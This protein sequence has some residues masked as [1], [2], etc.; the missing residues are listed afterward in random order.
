MRDTNKQRQVLLICNDVVGERMAGPGIR[1]WEFARVLSNSFAVTLTV[2]PFVKMKAFPGQPDFAAELV[3]CRSEAELRALTAKADVIVTLGIVPL[4]YPFLA[5]TDKPLVSDV[6]DPF[7]LSGL[8]QYADRPW[9]ERIA[10]HEGYR[11]AL[12]LQIEAADFFIC[13]S[14]KQRDYWLGMLSALGRINPYTHDDDHTL[15]RL[16]DVVP[17]G[18]PVEPPKHTT[19]VLK[20]VYKT[21]AADDKVILWGGGI[22]NWFDAPTLIRALASIARQRQDV[23]LFFMGVER[24]NPSLPKMQAGDEAIALSQELG[25][26]NRYVFFND[27]VPYSERQNYL[28]EADLGVSLHK[29]HAETRFAFRTRFLDYLWAGLPMVA[30]EG[31]VVS[32]QVKEWGLGRIVAAGDVEGVTTA[33]LELLDTPGLREIYRPRFAQ[34]AARY[35]WDVVTAPLVNFCANPRLA[36]D[37]AYRKQIP[38]VETGEATWQSL[39][40][41]AW[42][43]L[44]S[45]GASGLMRRV[46]EYLRWRLERW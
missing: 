30:T 1:Y 37:K 46:N 19:P 5:N 9:A 23:K 3:I 12:N 6:Y 32:E 14:E 15:R 44:R 40:A 28:L 45:Q 42:R 35:R 39:P 20:G 11:R 41:K 22:W 4:V 33:I 31:D 13:A 24:A 7:L 16:I 21:I 29:D 27:W 43:A 38:M 2:P 8:S 25:L 36:P 18:L 17:F 10:H 34:A 26:Y